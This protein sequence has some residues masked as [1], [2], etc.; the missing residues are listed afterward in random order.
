MLNIFDYF[1]SLPPATKLGQGY[2]F[3]LPACLAAGLQGGWYPS[4]PCRFPGPHPRGKLRGIWPGGSPGPHP[5][6][7]LRGIWPGGLQAH[8]QGGSPDP[9]LGGLQAHTGRGFSGP[10]LE[11]SIPACTEADTP[12]RLL[13]R[14]VR[15]LL[16]CILV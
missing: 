4:M 15:I 9:H 12:R 2:V 1:S 14:A 13:L 7:K 10:H 8:T 11:G 5:R 3:T 16:V 6:E